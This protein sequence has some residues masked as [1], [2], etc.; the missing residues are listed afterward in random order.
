MTVK[1]SGRGAG[2]ESGIPARVP[3]FVF[4]SGTLL[5]A[6]I[7]YEG[8]SLISKTQRSEATRSTATGTDPLRA[9]QRLP[10]GERSDSPR[11]PA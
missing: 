10:G 4:L 2:D 6:P 5:V 1:V 3:S 8:E 11:L 7:K 9:A